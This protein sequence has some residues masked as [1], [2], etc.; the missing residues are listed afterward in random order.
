MTARSCFCWTLSRPG[1]T[2]TAKRSPS[3]P[4]PTCGRWRWPWWAVSAATSP[5]V[6]TGTPTKPTSTGPSG[7]RGD[8][9]RRHHRGR[10]RP[11]WGCSACAWS[12]TTP[13]VTP[14]WSPPTPTRPPGTAPPVTR[15]W[16]GSVT[17]R[18]PPSSGTGGSCTAAASSTRPPTSPLSDNTKSHRRLPAAV[19][20]PGGSEG[21]SP[22]GL[23]QRPL[24]HSDLCTH[25]ADGSWDLLVRAP[26]V[27]DR[28][29]IVR[30]RYVSADYLTR[31]D[32]DAI[33]AA[34]AALDWPERQCLRPA[35]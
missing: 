12:A 3:S 27:I 13:T 16:P 7:N 29:G 34:L 4:P 24:T 21:P 32:P 33:E 26:L 22:R 35:I 17:A 2:C 19:H 18:T 6:A 31:M 10:P 11:G 1:R 5:P 20:R 8:R 23:P 28:S 14:G 15:S 9:P 25:N 30:A